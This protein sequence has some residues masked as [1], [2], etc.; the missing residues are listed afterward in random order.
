[1]DVYLRPGKPDINRKC[2]F[3]E[4]ANNTTAYMAPYR[5]WSL[6]IVLQTIFSPMTFFAAT[7]FL[8]YLPTRRFIF[9][10]NLTHPHYSGTMP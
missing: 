9:A 4:Q 6:S 8:L 7:R 3:A 10:F 5:P 2:V 1:L